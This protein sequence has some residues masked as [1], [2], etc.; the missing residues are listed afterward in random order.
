MNNMKRNYDLLIILACG[1]LISSCEKDYL[2]P[3]KVEVTTEVSFSKDIQPIFTEDCAKSGCHITGV[4]A[5]N[6]LEGRAYDELMG[7]GY[8]DTTNA[9]ASIL[10]VR[11]TAT[12]RPMPPAGRLSPEEIGYILAWIEQGAK[13]N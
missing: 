10:Y 7:L 8:V 5:P 9:E 4:Q 11:I 3:K 13:N 6:L 1:F 12:S 2:T